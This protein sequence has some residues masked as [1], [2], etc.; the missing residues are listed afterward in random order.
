MKIPEII[1]TF[2]KREEWVVKGSKMDDAIESALN[3]LKNAELGDSANEVRYYK[4]DSENHRLENILGN[5][6]TT[7]E[8]MNFINNECKGSAKC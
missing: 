4:Y 2:E 7:E 6:V 1:D 8:I 5:D 3:L